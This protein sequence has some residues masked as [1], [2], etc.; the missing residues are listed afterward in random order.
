VKKI[1]GCGLILLVFTVLTG[2]AQNGVLRAFPGAEGN[3]ADVTGGRGGRVIYV[4]N[5]DDNTSPGSL[6]YAINQSGARIIMFKVSGTIKLKSKL[7]ISK[8]NVTIAGQTAPGDGITLRDYSVVINTNNVIV[9]FLRF[10][11]GDQTNQEADAF[12]GRRHENIIIDHCSLSWS[13]DECG[14]FYDNEFFTLQWSILS[15]SL[16]NSVHGKGKHGYGGIWGGRGVSFHHNLLSCHDSRNPR[17]CG[18]RYSNKPD[19]ELVDYRNNVIYN[20]G[21][22]SAY[23][24]EGGRY[25]MVNNYYKAGPATSSSKQG[26]II[27][28]YADNGGNSQP[29]GTH[30]TFYIAGNHM[31]ESVA[32]THDNWQG[33]DLNS[34]FATYAPGVS[35]NDIKSGTEFPHAAVTTHSAEKAYEKVVGFCGASLKRDSVDL[36]IIHDLSTGTVTYT[37]GGNG[38]KNGLIDTQNAVGG[39]PVLLSA[40]APADADEDGMPDAW[41]KAN[42]LNPNDGGDAQLKSVDGTYPNVEVYL[43]SL[44]SEIVEKQ[45]Q[46]GIT[47][48][49]QKMPLNNETIKA[50][51]NNSSKEIII[52][53]SQV[54]KR[55]T[56]FSISG[57]VITDR[58]L[59]SA[60]VKMNINITDPGVYIIRMVDEKNRQ[61]SKKIMNY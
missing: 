51:W 39:W 21:G 26:R 60:S 16:R 11:M 38:S 57:T 18:S 1:I 40:D 8:P 14:S 28:P 23:A 10:R 33:V 37:N 52:N 55:I 34:S 31:T 5:L 36:R 48:T 41:E 42:N 22:N 59:Y 54:I 17:F 44:V 45:N 29:A 61:F 3:G 24:A 27:E 9:R 13:T 30:G 49:T 6:R 56:V 32:V 7:N 20:W 19:E 47:S 46:D 15:E 12:E 35:K 4:T 25:N 50:Y 2:F 53:H 58:N 43:Y